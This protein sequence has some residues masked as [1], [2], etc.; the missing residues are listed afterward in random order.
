LESFA[1][2]TRNPKDKEN[3]VGKLISDNVFYSDQ[4]SEMQYF[5]SLAYNHSP[6]TATNSN[7]KEVAQL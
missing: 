7:S 5:Q 3:L 4:Q 6:L 1:V 2:N